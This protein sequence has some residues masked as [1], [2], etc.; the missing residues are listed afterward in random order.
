MN[1]KTY[2]EKKL[3]EINRLNT[4]KE[5]QAFAKGVDIE[6]PIEKD[7]DSTII[8]DILKLREWPFKD[9]IPEKHKENQQ[10][11]EKV[12]TMLSSEKKPYKCFS[13]GVHDNHFYFGSIL[14]H[15]RKKVPVI[16]LDDGR[17][18]WKWRE[19]V[20]QEVIVDDEIFDR[21]RLN[22]R[23]ELFEDCV[24][25]LW[26]NDSIKKFINDQC[27]KLSYRDIFEK[28]QT[29]N[30]ELIYH[31]KK[32]AHD[33]I[34]C[35]IISNYHYP[36]FNAKGRTYFQADFA[37]G[38]SRQSLIYQKLSFNS[39]FASNISPASFERVIES[40]GG[41]I[42]VDNF[43]NCADELKKQ[44]LQC[45]EVYYKKGGKNIKADGKGFEKNKPI[46]FNGYS[47]L[48][49]NNII[50]LPEV[51]ESRCNKIQMLKT[52]IKSLVDIKINEDDSF[53]KELKDELHIL[54]LQN[55]K[56]VKNT[57]DKLEV[58][59]LSA[60]D[61]EKAE[62]VLTIAKVI[63]DDVYKSVLNF[64]ISNSEQQGIKD[65]QD[66][67]EFM[68]FEFLHNVLKSGETKKIK[69]AEITQCIGQKVVQSDRTS[70]SDKLKFSHYCGKI[71][72]GVVLF[73]KRIIGG[74]VYYE[75]SRKDL[76][77]ILKI[78]GYD[79]YLLPHLTTPNNTN[80]TNN[81]LEGDVCS[82]G[83]VKTTPG[84]CPKCKSNNLFTYKN[85]G[86]RSC[87]DCGEIIR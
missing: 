36:I 2:Y 7:T 35:D 10:K 55:W 16:I 77:K 53:W 23:F 15:G 66:N 14:E 51:T 45:I 6:R 34:A 1:K 81:T 70:K 76:D 71:L 39:L 17:I 19:R 46:A 59:E 84:L 52:N 86:I 74:W 32:E 11:I 31:A 83:D 56:K 65:L 37:S 68:L 25:N 3:Q 82:V 42:I 28:I 62:A 61:L 75:I 49:I 63:G 41:T 58:P 87:N 26:S 29:K 4:N 30:K 47:P 40:T 85:T 44:I 22:Y 12:N 78:K 13:I 27:E 72:S 38:K 9:D 67:W 21:F 60:R 48:V 50:G 64:L 69:I 33:Y 54:T 80:N 5:K 8:G 20:G 24:D 73:K 18:F 57:Y 43:D 79:K